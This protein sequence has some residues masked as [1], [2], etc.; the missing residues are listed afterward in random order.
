MPCI[1]APPSSGPQRTANPVTLLKIPSAQ[2]PCSG[3]NAAPNIAS[4]RGITSA[5]PA[6]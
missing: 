6:P 1:T 5:A 3:P 4:A 2:P